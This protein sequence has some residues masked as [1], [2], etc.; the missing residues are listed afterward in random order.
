MTILIPIPELALEKAL[1]SRKVGGGMMGQMKDLERI[2][3]RH[4]LRSSAMLLLGW[5]GTNG[6]LAH[7]DSMPSS[8]TK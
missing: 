6:Q 2:F 1:R 5:C 7:V 3:S 4:H 8:P